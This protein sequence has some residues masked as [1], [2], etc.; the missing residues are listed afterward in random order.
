M[1]ATI[2]WAKQAKLSAYKNQCNRD[3]PSALIQGGVNK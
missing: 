1:F 2:P 3:Y